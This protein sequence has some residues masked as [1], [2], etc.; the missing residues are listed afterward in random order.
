MFKY[1]GLY[2]TP[3]LIWPSAK[4]CLTSQAKKAIISMI[5]LQN[6]VGYFEMNELFK[7]FDTMVK[8]ILLYASEIWGYEY[9][10]KMELYMNNYKVSMYKYMGLY[11]TP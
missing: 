1:M 8:T 10:K 4:S 5:R 2:I 9:T 3:T 11:I 7:L 6:S